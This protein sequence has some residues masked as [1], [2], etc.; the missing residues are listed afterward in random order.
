MSQVF[1]DTHTPRTQGHSEGPRHGRSTQHQ[2]CVG[3]DEDG[4]WNPG[5][6]GRLL[7]AL[8][9]VPDPQLPDGPLEIQYQQS[10]WNKG[11][12]K[13]PVSLVSR[14]GVQELDCL[15]M[16]RGPGLGLRDGREQPR[17]S[18]SPLVSVK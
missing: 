11:H 10:C 1:V 5:D 6:S 7:G 14:T 2:H 15:G 16:V 8:P 12:K 4:A 17:A 13:D 18:H 9:W 3:E